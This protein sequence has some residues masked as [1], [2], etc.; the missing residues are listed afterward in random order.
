MFNKILSLYQN[1]IVYP[2]EKYDLEHYYF[3]KS[4]KKDDIFGISKKISTNEY[5]LI[6]TNFVEKKIYSLDNKIQKIYDYLLEKNPSPFKK[7]MRILIYQLNDQYKGIIEEFLKELISEIKIVD[8]LQYHVAIYPINKDIEFDKFFT[9]L[10]DDIGFPI[11][12]HKGLIITQSTQGEDVVKYIYAYDRT[13]KLKHNLYSEMP[14]L[15][16][17]LHKDDYLEIINI[18]KNNLF[19]DIIEDDQLVNLI[20]TFFENDLNVSQTAKQLYLHRNSLLNRL[21]N[22]YSQTGFNIQKFSHATAVKVMLSI[23]N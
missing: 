4:S 14:E 10:S 19:K 18:I 23:N 5:E 17:N 16:F 11:I 8:I 22:I 15:I 12:L 2:V 1:L 7:N 9:T 20:N 3:Y 21:E 6:K 13:N